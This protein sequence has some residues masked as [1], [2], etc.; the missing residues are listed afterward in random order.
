MNFEDFK[1]YAVAIDSNNIFGECDDVPTIVPEF[2]KIFYKKFNPIDVEVEI[3]NAI[4][5]FYPA[6]QLNIL[7]EEY[8]ISDVFIFATCNGDP[9]FIHNGAVYSCAHGN[10]KS[11]WELLT[12]RL[13][14]CF[15]LPQ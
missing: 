1:K 8:N 2:L 9:I 5:R 15:I 4:V 11:Q 6:N 14:K 13:Y 3:D 12:N 7:Q 10:D